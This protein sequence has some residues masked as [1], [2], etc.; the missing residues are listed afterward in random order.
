MYNE[1]I[2]QLYFQTLSEKSRYGISSTI[3]KYADTGEPVFGKELGEFTANELLRTAA[4]Q[5]YVTWASLAS[6]LTRL[7]RYHEWYVENYGGRSY[8]YNEISP[9]LVDISQSMKRNLV[10]SITELNSLVSKLSLGD[11]DIALPVAYMSWYG[12]DIN[13]VISLE[14]K[15]VL[16]TGDSVNIVPLEMSI[17]EPYAVKVFDDYKNTNS[18]I[19]YRRNGQEF[20]KQPGKCFIRPIYT[21]NSKWSNNSV[22][23]R[24]VNY[25]FDRDRSLLGEK[26][27]KFQ[28]KNILLSGQ[29]NA[30]QIT[31]KEKGF[32]SDEDVTHAL[33][34]ENVKRSSELNPYKWMLEMYKKAFPD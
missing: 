18:T 7:S 19:K 12:I 21:G 2:K 26:A 3:C 30:L 20:F 17:T 32:L 16:I 28:R 31:E 14:E 10:G 23:P 25:A 11:C 15:D 22:T 13:D 6:S 4:L 9:Y 27:Q 5:D 29:L 8:T 33:A 34:L 24:N 1:E